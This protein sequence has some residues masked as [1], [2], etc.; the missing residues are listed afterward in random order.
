M[1][2][3]NKPFSTCQVVGLLR[4]FNDIL[5]N[6]FS[7]SKTKIPILIRLSTI[8]KSYFCNNIFKILKVTFC[9]VWDHI[10]F[11][12][13]TV[14]FNLFNQYS[15]VQKN[16][17]ARKI[18][19]HRIRS[20]NEC[21]LNTVIELKQNYEHDKWVPAVVLGH[22]LQVPFQL[23]PCVHHVCYQILKNSCQH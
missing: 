15:F 22:L 19:K 11:F 3:L 5:Y 4:Y 7:F 20:W 14:E 8:L 23:N 13:N 1:Q 16:L 17:Q 10:I 18:R 2:I 12:F 21:L 9:A 6:V